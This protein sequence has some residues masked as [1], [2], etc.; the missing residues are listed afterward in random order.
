MRSWSRKSFTVASWCGW[1]KSASLASVACMY[2]CG[3]TVAEPRQLPYN[4]TDEDIAE[5]LTDE[6][7]KAAAEAFISGATTISNTSAQTGL[8]LSKE[9]D[10]CIKGCWKRFG[11]DLKKC[12]EDFTECTENFLGNI[13]F[14]HPV[15]RWAI[16]GDICEARYQLCEANAQLERATCILDCLSDGGSNK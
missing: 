10:K 4:L 12:M 6:D 7:I 15:Q 3:V 8:E 13:W 2:M 14:R 5:A 16:G 1:L 9:S 11:S